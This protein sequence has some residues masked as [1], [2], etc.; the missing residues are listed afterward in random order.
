M[1]SNGIV[2]LEDVYAIFI[3][4]L[5]NP[6]PTSPTPTTPVVV[7][8]VTETVAITKTTAETITTTRVTATPV[9]DY[10]STVLVGIIGTIIIAALAYA[11]FRKK[12]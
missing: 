11:L 8:T 3:E 9:P 4:A 12:Y 1:N 6:L 7:E 10:T 2:D 5:K